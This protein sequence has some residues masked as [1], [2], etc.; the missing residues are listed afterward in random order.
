[1]DSKEEKKQFSV[2]AR[3]K[4]ANH[5]WRGIGILVKAGHNMW[6]AIFIGVLAVYLGFIL[7]ISNTEWLFLIFTIG[8]VFIAEAFNTAIEIDINLTSP[9]FHPYARDT[10]DVAAGAVLI[11]VILSIIVALFIFAPKILLYVNM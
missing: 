10:K 2:S 9:E 5:A 11:S 6:G 3:I 7:N 8:L 1:M 4:S